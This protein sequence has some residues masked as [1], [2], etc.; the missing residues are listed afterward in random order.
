M[1][2]QVV[3]QGLD[4]QRYL[5]LDTLLSLQRPRAEG[6]EPDRV[7]LAEHFFIVVHQASELW[8]RQL[9]LDLDRAVDAV[10]GGRLDAA[11]EYLARVSHV[12]GLL[13]AHI[14]VLDRLPPDCFTR[15]RPYLGTASGAQ[16]VQFAEV[17]RVMGFGSGE[18]PVVAALR[19]AAGDRGLAEACLRDDRFLAVVDLLLEISG[20]YWRWKAAHLACV[21]RMLGAARGTGGTTGAEYLASRVRYPFP[22]L[23]DAR[24]EVELS[25]PLVDA[26]RA[27]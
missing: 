27:R 12:F 17:E 6:R 4:Y 15:F 18:A 26:G 13:Q 1:N 24:R 7:H 14:E 16:S 21:V 11:A 5:E 8:L 20:S 9:L 23:R 19:R 10:A 2:R 22:E 3:D 25:P